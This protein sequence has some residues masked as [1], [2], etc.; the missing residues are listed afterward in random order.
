M[1]RTVQAVGFG[2]STWVVTI[3]TIQ[4]RVT[5]A[6]NDFSMVG[7]AMTASCRSSRG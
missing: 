3:G 7:G 2:A 5:D 6:V 4:A 1:S